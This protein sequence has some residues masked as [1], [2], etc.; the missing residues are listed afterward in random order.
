MLEMATYK[1]DLAAVANINHL[2]VRFDI[3]G[4]LRTTALKSLG[5]LRA[6][7]IGGCRMRDSSWVRGA[8]LC[9]RKRRGCMPERDGPV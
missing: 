9:T 7:A 6:H 5:M 2:W 8:G 3:H 4:T 1:Q